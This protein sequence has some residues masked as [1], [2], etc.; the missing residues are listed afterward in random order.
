MATSVHSDTQTAQQVAPDKL[1]APRWKVVLLNDDYT[2]ME[3]VVTILQRYFQHSQQ[4]AM[5]I[6]LQVHHQGRAVAGTY[7]AEIAETKAAQVNQAAR[8]R[9]HPLLCVV[10][11]D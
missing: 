4:E 3:F 7:T 1:Q 5:M 2:P 11:K 8:Q 6:M 10:E 9:Q